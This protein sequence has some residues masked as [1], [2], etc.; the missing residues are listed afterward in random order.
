MKRL[1]KT[2]SLPALDL[3]WLITVAGSTGSTRYAVPK[4][5]YCLTHR[6]AKLQRCLVTRRTMVQDRPLELISGR[7]KILV[8]LSIRTSTTWFPTQSFEPCDA[9]ALAE[10]RK[11]G[12]PAQR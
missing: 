3:H 2:G 4:N 6:G 12:F 10:R 5:V 9:V 1:N 11:V 8:G 7:A